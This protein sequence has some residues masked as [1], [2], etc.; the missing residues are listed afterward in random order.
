VS[1]PVLLYGAYGYSGRLI[2][3]RSLE[4]GVRPILGGRDEARLRSVAERYGL[5]YRV[6]SV[7]DTE[8]LHA[9]LRDVAAVLNVA[10]PFSAT[11]LPMATACLRAGVHYL[12]ITGEPAVID[13]L[14]R[15]HAEARRR[16]VMLLPGA[17]FDVVASDCLV[18]HVARQ[19]ERPRRLGIAIQG[20]ELMSRGSALSFVEQAGVPVLVRCDG[21]LSAVPPGERERDF[22]F[23]NG[24]RRC[25]NV[26]WGDVVT[27]YYTTGIPDIEVYFDAPPTFRAALL[28]SRLMGPV[29]SSPVSQVWLKLHA[30]LL[31]DGP[32]AIE[33]AA[34]RVT[35]VVEIEDDRGRRAR[36]RLCTPQS[37]TFTGLAAAAVLRAVAAGDVE[38]GFQT[39]ARLYGPDFVL[40]L[41]GVSR[42]DLD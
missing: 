24:P 34:V 32:S 23:G 42:Q 26:S 30:D 2:L 8:S 35:V 3:E 12:D 17:G 20:L 10:G 39:P 13:T 36:S 6:S 31:P 19:V 22:D 4:I 25:V 40:S 21:A 33:R 14:A 38:P 41:E 11:A 16:G 18:A 37:Y 7:H 5:P 27:A 28:A 29:A 9:I 15:R 1:R